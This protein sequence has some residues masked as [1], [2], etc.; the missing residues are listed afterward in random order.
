M[1]R[2]VFISPKDDSDDVTLVRPS[3][4]NADHIGGGFLHSIKSS[5]GTPDDEFSTGTL[6]AKWTVVTGSSGSVDLMGTSSR[7]IY[8]LTTRA[9]CLLTQSGPGSTQLVDIRQDYTLPDG[10]SI[11]V[12]VG[13]NL[14]LDGAPGI[15]AN[16]RQTVLVLNSDDT[17]SQNGGTRT[18]LFAVEMDADS[19]DPQSI[20]T[21][22]SASTAATVTAG[23]PSLGDMVFLR[24]ARVGLVY[25]C[26][27]SIN[28]INWVGMGSQTFAAAHTNIWLSDRCF[29]AAPNPIPITTWA[30]VRLGTNAVDPWPWWS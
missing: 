26:Y 17:G 3:D 25:W 16:E 15:A 18:E 19:P 13:S 1:V 9:G 21:G 24:V 4:W 10:S 28:G 20:A 12:A 11:V 27:W 14:S 22:A 23:R 30:W 29:A 2:H 8:D 5:A 7:Q 6:D